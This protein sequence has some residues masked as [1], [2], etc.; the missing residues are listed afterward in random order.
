MPKIFDD[1]EDEIKIIKNK[2]E[3]KKKPIFDLEEEEEES[4]EKSIKEKRSYRKKKY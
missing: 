2:K 3:I 1:E 4:V